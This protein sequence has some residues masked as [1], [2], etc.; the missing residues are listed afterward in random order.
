[1]CVFVIVGF[2]ERIDRLSFRTIG[3][4][5]N[6]AMNS[7]HA[8]PGARAVVQWIESPG[9]QAN[10]VGNY[11]GMAVAAVREGGRYWLTQEFFQV[12]GDFPGD[13]LPVA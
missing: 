2:S 13:P 5:E 11:Q 7:A 12:R 9:H 4:A 3:A 8:G 1:M 10:L 6:V